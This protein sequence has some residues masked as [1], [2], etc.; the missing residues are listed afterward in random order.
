MPNEHDFN[1]TPRSTSPGSSGSPGALIG[2]EAEI[3]RIRGEYADAYRA[4]LAPDPGEYVKRYP[5]FARELVDYF[6]YFHTIAVDL[7]TPDPVPAPQLNPA[8]QA[9]METI[10]AQQA[11]QGMLAGLVSRGLELGIVP[12]RLAEMV[13]LSEDLLEKLDEHA[14][15]IARIP[16]ALIR[17]FADALKA[18]P[19]VVASFLDGG[20]TQAAP[21]FFHADSAPQLKQD[22]FLDAVHASD[23]TPE[24]QQEWERI[25]GEENI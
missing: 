12:Q 20:Q 16:G 13:G 4:G 24:Q 2:D 17:R 8:A 18:T 15:S 6:L 25:V 21:G 14:I 19:E 3:A 9:A 7:P 22:D 1:E 11:P 5:Q 23:L 10:R